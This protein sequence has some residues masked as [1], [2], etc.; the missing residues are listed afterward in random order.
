MYSQTQI[1]TQ[2]DSVDNFQYQMLKKKKKKREEEEEE[3]EGCV[4]V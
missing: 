1:H 2:V 3:E 4:G